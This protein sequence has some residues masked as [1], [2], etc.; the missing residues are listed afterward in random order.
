M[1]DINDFLDD[2]LAIGKL[3]APMIHPG[4]PAAIAIGER[5]IGLIDR[6]TSKGATNP[7]L[8]ETRA[9]LES[10]VH[11]KAKAEADKLRGN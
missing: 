2:A 3:V 5:V 4:A 8:A 11:A 9:E 10:R 7:E 1:S 6:L